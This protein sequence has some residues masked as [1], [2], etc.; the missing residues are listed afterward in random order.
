MAVVSLILLFLG[1]QLSSGAP[2]SGPVFLS[3]P[4]ANSVLQRQ[5]RHNTGIFE[6]LL[7]GNLERECA[8]E[9]CD[10]EE[11]REIFENDEKTTEFWAKYVAIVKR[12]DV[13]N[14]DCMHFCESVGTSATKCSCATGYRLMKNGLNCEPEVPFPCGRTALMGVRSIS[15]RSVSRREITNLHNRTSLSNVSA[16]TS[17]P[18]APASNTVSFPTTNNSIQQQSVKKLPL[19]V[20]TEAED[21]T[22]EEPT[23]EEPTVEYPSEE[24]PHPFRRI[25]GGTVVVPGE[26]PWQVALIA[27]TSGQ[28]FCGGSI[29]SERWVITAAHC[30]S[31]SQGPF[32]VRVGE[33]NIYINEGTEQ[34]HEVLERH[35][36]PLYNASISLYNHDVALLH[37]KKRIT[38]SRV[39]RPICIGP[40]AFTEALMKDSLM[41]TVSGWGRTRYLGSTSNTLQKIEVPFTDRTQCKHSSSARITRVM[42]C[43]GYHNEAKDACQG[44]SGGPHANIFYDTWFLTGIVSWGEECAKIGKYG[45]YTHVSLYYPW[46]NFVMGLTKHRPTLDVEGPG[47]YRV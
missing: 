31:V 18:S 8:E 24:P 23:E 7:K 10:F 17:P 4:A 3:S 45:V 40:R 14:G 37:L 43:A 36:Y 42:F 6:E 47:P 13:N 19:W 27:H 11:A 34:D 41:A 29:L 26:I 39:V 20:Y 5:K 25:V 32:F 16:A 21:P 22:E 44:D 33:H 12:C 35:I 1:F 38:F 46:I 30:L 15:R 2:S 9:T 28:V